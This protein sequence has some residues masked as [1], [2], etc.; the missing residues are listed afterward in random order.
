MK[1]F[2]TFMED[3]DYNSLQF[4]VTGAIASRILAFGKTLP[5]VVKRETEPHITGKYGINENLSKDLV[6]LV[7]GFGKVKVVL[8]VTS[9]FEGEG[10]DVLK[11]DVIGDDIKRFNSMIV[12]NIKCIDKFPTYVP[13]LTIAYMKRGSAAPYIMDKRFSG[14]ELTFD[15]VSFCLKDGVKITMYLV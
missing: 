9:I 14:T 13:H 5:D 2:K 15:S 3:Y 10:H 4:E 1:N 12:R 11:I 8:G 6:N 7:T